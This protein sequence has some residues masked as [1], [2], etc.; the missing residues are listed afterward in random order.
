M[1]AAWAA[2]SSWLRKGPPLNPSQDEPVRTKMCDSPT[3]LARAIMAAA[4]PPSLRT[5]SHTHMPLPSG[6]T[7]GGG[8]GGC[9][10]WVTEVVVAGRVVVGAAGL[11]AGR[12][13]VF[14]G[15]AGSVV[16]GSVGGG[17]G[18]VH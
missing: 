17:P 13:G 2:G 5:G 12:A 16:G 9:A 3:A 8:G 4:L 1:P 11:R 18:P 10:G 14:A 6:S 7:G 15:R